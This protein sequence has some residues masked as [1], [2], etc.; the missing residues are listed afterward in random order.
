MLLTPHA[1]SWPHRLVGV[2]V[3]VAAPRRTRRRRHPPG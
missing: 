3:Q 1:L 2:L